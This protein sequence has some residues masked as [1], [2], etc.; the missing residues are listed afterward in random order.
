MIIML[1]YYSLF[2]ALHLNNHRPYDNH[3]HIPL[4]SLLSIIIMIIIKGEIDMMNDK[5]ANQDLSPEDV[6]NMVNER[7]RLEEAFQLAS[8][9]KASFQAKIKELE[10][11]LRGKG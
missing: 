7:Q 6:R 10:L 11:I 2:S 8:E 9:N 1:Y 5:I 4:L 3:H